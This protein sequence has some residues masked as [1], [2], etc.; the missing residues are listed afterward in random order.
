MRLQS[1]GVTN[2]VACLGS[3]WN[4]KHFQTLSKAATKV[5]FIPDSD[6]IKPSERLP[7][8]IKVVTDAGRL[9]FKNG[10]AVYVKEIPAG[11]GKRDADSYFTNR[12]MFDSL[13]EQDFI[14]W[15]AEKLFASSTSVD[16]QTI[17]LHTVVNI[18]TGIGNSTKVDFYIDQLK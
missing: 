9:A 17:A 14:L 11:D 15:Y 6:V 1:I 7:H 10:L 13:P 16:D 8:G 18:L 2:S 3:A 5:C 4:E 12:E